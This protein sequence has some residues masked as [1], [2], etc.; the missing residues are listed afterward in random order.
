MQRTLSLLAFLTTALS[1]QAATPVSCESSPAVAAEIRSFDH[2]LETASFKEQLALYKETV[3]R[4]ARLDPEDI[5]FVQRYL[6][7][8]RYEAPDEL[9]TLR[10]SYLDQA[11]KHPDD[12]AKLSIA[13][14]A[15]RS[16]DTP[17]AFH[18]LEQAR[19]A[20][21]NY[22]P[23]DVLLAN[24]YSSSGKFT[25]KTKA[26]NY[27]SD[28]YQ[29]CPASRYSS[30]T[31]LLKQLGS[32][33]LK[34]K[35]A[36]NLRQRLA[37]TSDPYVLAS[38][39]DVW[40]LEFSTLAVPE[41]PKERQRIADDLNRLQKLPASDPAWLTFLEAGYKQSG[42]PPA[43]IQEIE[44][45]LLKEFPHS[46]EAL[47]VLYQR[48][49]KD[50]PAPP[51][52]ASAADWQKYLRDA[53]PQYRQWIAEFPEAY[54]YEYMIFEDLSNLDGVSNDEL[55]REGEAYIRTMDLHDGEASGS[56]RF[57]A[58]IFLDHNIQ[59][60]RAFDLLESAR[61]LRGSS[62]EK[63]HSELA[64]YVT[65]NDREKSNQYRP[66][67]EASFRVLYLRA[68]RA[69]GNT[70]AAE[71][72]KPEIESSPADE[73][74]LAAINWNARAI[75]AEIEGQNT[76]ALAYFQKALLLREP[77]KKQ[78]GK[79]N[80]PLLSDAKQ[81]WTSTGGSETAFA[82]WSQPG[83]SAGAELAEGR[84]EKP[85]KELPP[86]ELADL[87]GKT[88]KL[89]SLEGKKL[90]INIWATWCGPCQGELPLLQKLYEQIKNRSDIAILTLN[91]DEDPGLIEPFVKEKGYTFPVLL[92]YSF[93]SNK[94]DVNSIPRNWLVDANG[95]WQWEQIGFNSG[96]SD[97]G[98]SMLA[99]LEDS[100]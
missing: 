79:L 31:H 39:E 44:D 74:K 92:A 5:R 72:L 58:E 99:R 28:Y 23:A 10:D 77:P 16:K 37:N 86:F 89:K 30:A 93:L 67:N 36:K 66:I 3:T 78:F 80:D 48:W 18:L 100:K 17:Q 45:R 33:A 70:A 34:A 19:A 53:I 12:P 65:D 51:A 40:S 4:V 68:C 6:G 90:L 21:A 38:M 56:R 88:W 76:D 82:I 64:D 71:R 59:P 85:S 43:R 61:T 60:F 8:L 97:W 62:K 25:D 13:A 27:L 22:A 26:A 29:L 24:F 63:A 73:A 83:K 50:R 75:L 52:E 81:L 15:L 41:Y 84:W 91:L 69:T 32:P 14:I 95:K 49:K 96:E 11:Q 9:K 47:G 2:K 35:V 46:D 87:Q 98:K 20:N 54:D 94:L 7:F 42:A 55:A 1:V 57:A